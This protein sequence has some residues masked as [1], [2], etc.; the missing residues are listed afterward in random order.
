MSMCLCVCVWTGVNVWWFVSLFDHLATATKRI[1]NQT[2]IQTTL[3]NSLPIHLPPI[4]PSICPSVC[5]GFRCRSH[6]CFIADVVVGDDDGGGGGMYACIQVLKDVQV[7]PCLSASVC[8]FLSVHIWICILLL[9]VVVVGWYHL[10][11]SKGPLPDNS[12][13]WPFFPLLV[14]C[15]CSSY[16][17]VAAFFI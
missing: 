14:R 15:C 7:Y 13:L 4:L 12:F 11:V 3:P 8:F 2:I 17:C 9:H 6:S 16:F 1:A 5:P 10:M